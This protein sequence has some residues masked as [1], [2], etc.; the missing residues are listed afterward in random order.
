LLVIG[1]GPLRADRASAREVASGCGDGV[2]R[3]SNARRGVPILFVHGFAG[4]PS[5]FRRRLAGRASMLAR[6]RDLEGVV[7]YTFDYSAHSLEWV[8]SRAIG[9]ALGA[10]IV[11]LAREQGAPVTVVAHS[12]GGLAAREAQGEL[13]GGVPV[14][15]SLGSVI[16]VGTPFLGTQL[17][18][19]ADG[20]GGDVLSGVV[21]TALRACGSQPSMRPRRSLCDL[22]GATDTAAVQGMIP[23]SE[24]LRSLPGWSAAVR[25]VP[26]A[27]EIEAGIEGPFGFSERFSL[28]DFA[29]S[30]DSALADASPGSRS[31][32]ASCHASLLGLVTAVDTSPCSHANELA[33]RRIIEQ[34]RDRVERAVVRARRGQ[35][36][37]TKRSSSP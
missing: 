25:I 1:A 18:G 28:G 8:T 27:A 11:C 35:R 7:A 36:G 4:A 23:G 31:F 34:V 20:P 9:P 22:L 10:A 3:V 17:L 30:V 5:D 29:V 13:V 33:N 26:M 24:R 12:M 2:R 15:A 37:S 21:E 32:V 6:V 14:A 16:T 19:F